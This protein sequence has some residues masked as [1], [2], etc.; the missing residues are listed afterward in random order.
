MN[1]HV[2][3]TMDALK[4]RLIFRYTHVREGE[5]ALIEVGQTFQTV[6]KP[7]EYHVLLDMRRYNLILDLSQVQQFAEYWANF[8][9][10]RDQGR[11]VAI[12][13][14]DPVVRLRMSEYGRIF[15]TR[16]FALFETFDE[17]LDWLGTPLAA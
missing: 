11:R 13:S 9:Q 6:D 15:P 16:I 4:R 14:T 3:F 5:N 7:W 12:V 8:M 17:G 2:G 10:G 1:G